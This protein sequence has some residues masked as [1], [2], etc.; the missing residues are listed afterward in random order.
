MTNYSSNEFPENNEF[1]SR[2]QLYKESSYMP[3]FPIQTLY[4]NFLNTNSAF[5]IKSEKRDKR[6]EEQVL[7]CSLSKMIQLLEL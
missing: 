1:E 5:S 2:E 4:L 6:N 7:K 3:R